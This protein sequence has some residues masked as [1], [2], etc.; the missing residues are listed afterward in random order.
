M[1]EPLK[2]SILATKFFASAISAEPPPELLELEE[3]EL[4]ELLLDEELLEL[5][6]LP[7]L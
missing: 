3:E 1:R 2:V 6:E 5:E 7:L 4:L